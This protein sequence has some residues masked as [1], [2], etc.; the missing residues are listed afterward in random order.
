MSFDKLPPLSKSVMAHYDFPG[1]MGKYNQRRA[2]AKNRKNN[3]E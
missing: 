1:F 2:K 3:C